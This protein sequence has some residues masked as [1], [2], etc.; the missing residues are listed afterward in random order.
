[1]KYL[2]SFWPEKINR[3]GL[4]TLS[5]YW[6]SFYSQSTDGWGKWG[7]GEG[8]GWWWRA[9]LLL[10][11][12]CLTTK[13]SSQ[14]VKS[15]KRHHEHGKTRALGFAFHDKK[16]SKYMRDWNRDWNGPSDHLPFLSQ[17]CLFG[18]CLPMMKTCLSTKYSE[19]KYTVLAVFVAAKLGLDLWQ[20]QIRNFISLSNAWR[21]EVKGGHRETQQLQEWVLVKWSAS[22]GDPSRWKDLPT[23]FAFSCLPLI[24]GIACVLGIL[25]WEVPIRQLPQGQQLLEDVWLLPCFCSRPP[26]NSH[27]P[28]LWNLWAPAALETEKGARPAPGRWSTQGTEGLALASL[29]APLRPG[30][31]LGLHCGRWWGGQ[32][33]GFPSHAPP[34]ADWTCDRNGG[35]WG[36]N[37]SLA[38]SV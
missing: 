5:I 26:P 31:Q 2:G 25:E 22:H 32:S 10:K 1:M 30:W 8:K 16:I 34:Y 15:L 12:E 19:R 4:N 29:S 14:N 21:R 38:V 28:L 27:H 3:I 9:S 33:W 37:C 18:D 17:G 23:H 6:D 7:M 13:N 11:R 20:N 24:P 35:V 36:Y